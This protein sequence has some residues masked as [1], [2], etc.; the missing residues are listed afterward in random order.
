[1]LERGKGKE[2]RKEKKGLGRAKGID[3]V[4]GRNDKKGSE[5]KRTKTCEF[6]GAQTKKSFLLKE[7]EPGRRNRRKGKSND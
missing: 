4:V 1:V 6:F 7:K 5:H 2:Q 3:H